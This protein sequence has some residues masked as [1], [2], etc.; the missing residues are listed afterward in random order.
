MKT[1]ITTTTLLGD[2]AVVIWLHT[3]A[4]PLPEEWALGVEK[5]CV[6]KSQGS[7]ERIRGFVV[8]DG[9]APNVA[10]RRQLG[11]IF[12]GRP[13]KV[14]LVTNSLANPVKRCVATAVSWINPAFKAV[15]P[16][17]WRDAL[18]HLDL[19]GEIASL[20]AI[21]RDLQKELPRVTSLVE[22]ERAVAMHDVRPR[23]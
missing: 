4:D 10:Q 16:S 1:T 14:S 19:E 8:S 21:L 13:N 22:L 6:L 2:K 7:I 18:R 11:E 3:A 9:G 5:T 15:P 23:A 20:L 12:G 17:R